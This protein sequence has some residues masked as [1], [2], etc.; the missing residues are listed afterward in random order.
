MT[1]SNEMKRPWPVILIAVLEFLAAAVACAVSFSLFVPGTWL[2]RMWAL[3]APVHDAFATQARPVATLLLLIGMLAAVAA[4]GML[5]RRVWAWL[6]SLT[7][8]GINALGDLVSVLFT[9]D[10]RHGLSGIL[11]DALFLLL[12]LRAGVRS[13]FLARR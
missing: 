3:N 11:I 10:W 13:W 9:R 5:A 12:L 1:G 6:L 7:I 8:F 4:V 2:D